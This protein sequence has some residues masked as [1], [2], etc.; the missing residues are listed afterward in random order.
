M[1]LVISSSSSN[2][3]NLVRVD[4]GVPKMALFL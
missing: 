3:I 1:I 2:S 4:L